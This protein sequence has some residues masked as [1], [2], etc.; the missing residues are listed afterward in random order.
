MKKLLVSLFLIIASFQLFSQS[1]EVITDILE[2]E[3]VTFGQICYLSAVQQGF[4]DENATYK[5]AIESLYQEGQI[6]V[7]SYEASPVPLAN[8]AYV[9]SQLWN[10]KGGLLYRLFNGAPR[11]AYKQMK[12]DGVLP[13]NADPALLISGQEAL[14]IYTSCSIKYGN[15]TLSID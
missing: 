4:I 10:I 6:P 14:N 8:I 7:I 3:Q 1:A 11:Y 2:T 15:M 9:F 13:N 12:A 5:D